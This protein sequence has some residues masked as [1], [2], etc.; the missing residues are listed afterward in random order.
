MIAK[1][2]GNN[3]PVS[4]AST[5]SVDGLASLM[6]AAG[7]PG[8]SA[9]SAG[10]VSQRRLVGLPAA[11]LALRIAATSISELE[12]GVYRGRDKDRRVVRTTWQSRFFDG[13]PNVYQSWASLLEMTEA[14]VTG[15]N[16]AFW[17][18]D[19][20]Q[21]GRPAAAHF[22]HA[23]TVEGRWKDDRP[24]YRYRTVANQWS[25]W[26]ATRVLHFRVDYVDPGCLIPPTPVE[27]A[28]E[29]LAAMIAKPA[30]AR[31][32]LERSGGRQIA[33]SYPESM[34]PEQAE[35]YRQILE[36]LLTGANSSGNV[37]VFGGGPEITTIGLSMAD[38]QFVELMQLDAEQIGQLFGVPA[39]LLQVMRNDRPLSPEH[40]E[41][42]WD[43]YYLGPRRTRIEQTL[44]ASPLFF[45][46]GSRDYPAFRSRPVRADVRGTAAAL[47]ALVQAG[48]LLPD[49]ARAEYG[50]EDLPD[51]VGAIPQITPVGGA[52]NP[53][54]DG[55]T[56]VAPAA[57]AP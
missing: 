22:M 38:M 31:E 27:I 14:S 43:R 20:D 1:S 7:L 36:P 4:W 12:L 51:G 49:E 2:S 11:N 30:H 53:D 52:P 55:G 48:I 29:I 44:S 10:V 26:T 24:E 25:E 28:R 54:L 5:R 47:V 23:D 19:V 13:Q 33:V 6:Q 39:S 56:I 34:K 15:R 9:G 8:R 17:R 16:N 32:T 18:L 45:G 40:E 41:T 46:Q 57:T 42:R 3:R 37:R 21:Q 50:K 35:R